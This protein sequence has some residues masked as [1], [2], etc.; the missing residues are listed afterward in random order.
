MSR[1]GS[2]CFLAV[3]FLGSL[4]SAT[5]ADLP[6][7]DW[8]RGSGNDLEMRLQGKILD[9]NGKPASDAKLEAWTRTRMGR[10][11]LQPSFDAGR[12]TLWTPVNRTDLYSV[13]L[14]ATSSDGKQ[15]AC[16]M[17]GPFELRQA[18]IDGIAL[19]L[20]PTRRVDVT[21]TDQSQPVTGAQVKAHFDSGVELL[22]TTD[23]KGVATFN[24]AGR[25]QLMFLTAWDEHDQ[26]GRRIGARALLPTLPR[27]MQAEEQ[28]IEL[29]KCRE[30]KIRFI[31]TDGTPVSGIEFNL[32]I[33]GG[34]PRENQVVE[35]TP[36]APLTS[37]A[38]GE[39]VSKW[40][41][42]WKPANSAL[43][44]TDNAWFIDGKPKTTDDAIVCTLSKRWP[45]KTVSGRI[46][47]DGVETTL[48]G[49]H[50]FLETFWTEE[51]NRTDMLYTFTNVDGA[52]TADVLPDTPYLMAVI[53]PRYPSRVID[54]TLYESLGDKVN[55]PE[56]HIAYGQL[57]EV[58][59]SAGQNSKPLTNLP[60]RFLVAHRFART[61]NGKTR[62]VT[63][64]IDWW[65]MTDDEGYAQTRA[66]PGQLNVEIYT[67]EW[68]DRKTI[69]VSES[70]SNKVN[71]HR[72][73]DASTGSES[74]P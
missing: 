4:I 59:T 26:A 33:S 69:N 5:A 31:T 42:D 45:R 50:V 60:V 10:M 13:W 39:A 9:A 1:F 72:K 62:P 22:S 73:E 24:V 17:L 25:E 55:S 46:V 7:Q 56:L 12:F 15:I 65:A 18:A 29:S 8:L 57:V 11:L 37:N 64:H 21:V 43:E 54:Q 27:D 71:L 40:F 19:K 20:A 47:A 74:K 3:I 6:A 34:Q 28:T 70:E 68:G 32:K 49:F 66:L 35:N 38:K 14:R 63:G 23:A 53:D 36:D 30:Q 52:F 44:M 67:G 51:K 41:P 61:V 58:T 16:H 2:L 48:G